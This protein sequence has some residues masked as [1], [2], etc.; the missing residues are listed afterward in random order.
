MQ[1]SSLRVS[2]FRPASFTN[3]QNADDTAVTESITVPS[4][5]VAATSDPC[6]SSKQDAQEQVQSGASVKDTGSET[7][8]KSKKDLDGTGNEGISNDHDETIQKF[9]HEHTVENDGTKSE[10]TLSPTQTLPAQKPEKENK[11]TQRTLTTEGVATPSSPRVKKRSLPS[12]P[13]AAR[14][15]HLL[16]AGPLAPKRTL[17]TPP[18]NN[19][20]APNYPC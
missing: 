19:V 12:L 9:H 4:I 6:L 18:A 13:T 5:V 8:E 1:E 3:V 14:S 17:P 10:V 2:L 15:G 20:E 16:K 11:S 7:V